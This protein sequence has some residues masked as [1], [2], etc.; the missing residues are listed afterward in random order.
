MT[1]TFE[2]YSEST[3]RSYSTLPTTDV[4]IL[5][6]P[7][8]CQDC[9]KEVVWN[10]SACSWVHAVPAADEHWTSPRPYCVYCHND[11]PGTVH[12][13]QRAWSDETECLRCGGVDGFAIGD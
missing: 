5:D 3:R 2:K 10:H 8:H 4:E 11:E 9:G 13:H 6:N 1:T 7:R 12:F